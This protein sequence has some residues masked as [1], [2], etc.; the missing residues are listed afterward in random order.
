MRGLKDKRVLITGAAAGIGR[1]TAQRFLDEGAR[2]ILCDRVAPA[3]VSFGFEVTERVRYV[4]A[5]V[6]VVEGLHAVERV[7]AETG[8]DVLINNAGITRDASV[9]KMQAS[10]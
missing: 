4:Q 6:S 2:L 8:V 7:V 1:A 3:D 10:D 9:L 5:D